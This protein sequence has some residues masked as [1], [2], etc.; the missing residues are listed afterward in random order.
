MIVATAGHVDHGKTA[1]VRALT[2]IDTDRLPE[3]QRRGMTIEAGYAHADLGQGEPVGFVDVP[4]HE[5]FIR[6]MLTGVSGVDFALLV[7]AGDDG[8]MP[9]TLEHL[10]V[11]DLLCIAHGACVLTKS[12]R[13]DAAR[14]DEVAGAMRKLLD[15]TCLQGAPLFPVSA[16]TGAGLPAVRSC[17]AEAQAA[18]PARPADGRFRL[19]VDRS[20]TRPGA[21]LVVTGTVLSG[22]ARVGDEVVAAPS[23]SRLR[24]R[25][26]QRHGAD[27]TEARAGQ[28]C[29]LNLAAA[30]GDRAVIERGD[31]VVAGAAY[32]PTA[33]LD[34]QLRVLSDVANGVPAD[35]LL[36][37]HLGAATRQARVAPLQGRRLAAGSH[38]LVQLV[39]DAPVSTL[40]GDR[41]ILRNAA[42]HRIVGGGRV[43]D[44]F[45]PA[46]GRARPQ[47]L[48][49]LEALACDSAPAACARLLDAHPEGLEFL[50]FAQSWNLDDAAADA[51]RH[52]LRA[53]EVPHRE[54]LRLVALRHW[55]DVHARIDAVLADWHAAHPD[56]LGL[57]ESQLLA[58]CAPGRG[59]TLVARAALRQRVEAGAVVRGGLLLRLASHQAELGP[60]DAARLV[61]LRTV[62][63]PCG[64]RPPPLGDIAPLL[65]LEL[66]AAAAFLQRAAQLGHVVQVAKNRFFLPETLQALVQVARETAA[67][68][69]GGRFDAASFRNRSGVGRNLS[70]QLLEFF[71][72]CRI[73]RFAAGRRAIVADEH[74]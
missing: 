63:A 64:L 19:A 66:D 59:D 71:D 46:R 14:L 2:G 65:D 44:P 30:G 5:H 11:L 57:G 69:P 48:A 61:Q 26:I 31:W 41:F 20:F 58:A 22:R 37:L 35:A 49:D 21:G 73:T 17:L 7:V 70:I 60:E 6:N 18:L 8:P 67:S 4:G 42:E 29:A 62:L 51:L 56:H 68:D 1:L 40:R 55:S 24:V 50:P 15:A 16:L 3:E 72:R 74:A 27:V 39:L 43:L 12:D 36:Q 13:V 28:R 54:G 23:G 25:A 33:R 32:A 10:A 9:Q 38:E 47:R 52:A 45:A 53:Q 34:V